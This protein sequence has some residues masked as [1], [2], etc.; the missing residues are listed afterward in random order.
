MIW[1]SIFNLRLTL[2]PSSAISCYLRVSFHPSIDVILSLS[3]TSPAKLLW[4]VSKIYHCFH[5]IHLFV[6]KLRRSLG[7]R[8]WCLSNWLPWKYSLQ[9]R[10]ACR[11]F[12]RIR[13]VPRCK[14]ERG[15]DWAER[16][17]D[18]RCGF[19]GSWSC[20][21]RDVPGRAFKSLITQSL[22]PSGPLKGKSPVGRG[23]CQVRDTVKRPSESTA[24][25]A[26]GWTYY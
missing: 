26:Q 21:C 13:G 17:G 24:F 15:Q 1:G 4:I 19:N 11:R 9:Y 23:Q 2:L 3:V 6:L 18:P 25:A 7:N 16:E 20:N 5:D 10:D 14:E 22:A 8:Q 12:M